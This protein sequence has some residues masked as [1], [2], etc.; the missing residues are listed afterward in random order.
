MNLLNSLEKKMGWLAIGNLPLYIVTTQA[1]VYVWMMLNPGSGSLL[2]LHPDLVVHRHEYWRLI[3]FLFVLDPLPN[4][5]FA[6]FFLYLLY[7]YGTALEQTWGSFQFT[8][9]Y[10]TGAVGTMIAAFVFGGADGAFYLNTS[11]FLAF[12]ALHP[13]FQLLLFFIIP[14]KIKWLAWLTWA[15]FA[16]NFWG[17]PTSAKVALIASLLNYFLFFGWTHALWVVD[18]V[19]RYRH[20]QRYKNMLG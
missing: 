5:L 6:F 8:L 2:G 17:S 15:Y 13:D 10:L 14:V 11:I 9:F 3:T 19:R 16:Y 20:R 4:P 18:V 12:A 1:I 7:V